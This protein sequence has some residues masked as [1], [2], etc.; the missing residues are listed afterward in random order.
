MATMKGHRRNQLAASRKTSSHNRSLWMVYSPKL[1]ADLV[2]LGDLEIIHWATELETNPSVQAYRFD[3][4]VNISLTVGEGED[5]SNFTK[6]RGIWVD[7]RSGAV[8]F[9]QIDAN[10]KHDSDRKSIPIRYRLT[11]QVTRHAELVSITSAHLTLVAYQLGFWLKVIAFA[12]QLRGYKLDHETELVGTQVQLLRK[13]TIR[14][15]LEDLDIADQAIALGV[16]CRLIISGSV[17]VEARKDGFGY[18][19]AWSAP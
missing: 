18:N 3:E 7:R 15:L 11:D 9:H 16:I 5:D 12:S 19:T 13:G 2:I 4:D 14:S 1:N 8:E 17:I 10:E 6:I